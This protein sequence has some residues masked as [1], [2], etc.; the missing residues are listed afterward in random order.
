MLDENLPR[1][2]RNHLPQHDVVTAAYAGL[3]GYK[4]GA[5]LQAAN[6]AGFDVLVT[7]DKTLRYEQNLSGQNLALVSLSANAWQIIRSRVKKISAAVDAATPESFTR[8][9]VGTFSRG[10]KP[11]G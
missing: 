1:V 5:L 2:F 4:N 3:A 9:D 11:N 10:Q 8:V 7:G 6:D